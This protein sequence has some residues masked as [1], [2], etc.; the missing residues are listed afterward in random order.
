[1][2]MVNILKY[3]EPKKPGLKMDYSTLNGSAKGALLGVVTFVMVFSAFP[4]PAMAAT[5]SPQALFSMTL[6]APTSNP[7]RRQWAAIITSS[8]QSVG[9]GA[10]LVF[11]SFGV[12]LNTLFNCPSGC[13][14]PTYSKGG[15]DAAFIGFG[16]GTPLPDF[17]TQD[18]VVYRDTGPG[19]VPPVGSNYYFFDNATYNQLSNQYNTIFDPAAR[20]PILQQMV[21]IVAQER[22]TLV[23]FYPSSVWVWT[24]N[25]KFYSGSNA[26]SASTAPYIA[27]AHAS[28]SSG[29]SVTI[30]ETGDINAVNQ[31]PT[32]AQNS[33]YDAYLYGPVTAAGQEIDPR[34]TCYY[35]ALVTKIS[36]SSDH[37]TWT[38]SFRPHTF[39][40]GVPVTSNDYLFSIMSG[41]RSDVGYVGQGS[42]QSILGLNTQFTYLN[43]TTDYVMNGTYY[44]GTA[45][46]GF[47]PNTTFTAVNSTAWSFHM[48]TPYV[49]TNPVITGTGSLAMH[50]YEKVPAS[51]WSSSFLSGF[52]GSSGGLSTNAVTVTWDK[53]KY[54][55][56]G[57]Y[58]YVYGPVGDGPY[59]YRGYDPVAQ[60]GTLVRY[61]G[62]WNA[63]GLQALGEFNIKTI[64]VQYIAGKDA[65]IAA[66]T[67]G[68]ANFLDDN[69]Q[70]NAQDV[71]TLRGQGMT[72]VITNDPSNGWQEMGLN[73]NNP[74]FGTGTGTPLGQSN[75]SQAAF[76]ARM[77]RKAISY[78]IP[79]QYIVQN[80]LGGL[81]SVGITQFCPCFTYA[82]PPSVQPDPYDPTAAKSFLAAAGYSTGV[83][84][85]STGINIPP[86][87][88]VSIGGSGIALPNFL[89]GNTFTASG[90]FKV[91][92]ILGANSGG[93]A[94]TLEQSTDGG[95]T[96]APVALGATN[97]G[98]Y[99]SISYTPTT[100]GTIQYRVFFTGLPEKTVIQDSLNDPATVESLVPPIAK[101]RPLN[102][103]DIQY[104]TVTTL[105]VGTLGQ[106]FAA[107]AGS[108]NSA[109]TTLNGNVQ[110]GLT[111]LQTSEKSDI[112]TVSTQVNTLSGQL[113]T[114]NGQ[115]STLTS[116]AYAALAVAIILGLIAIGLSRRKP[117]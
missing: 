101:Q 97:T 83:A 44:H 108:I 64:H 38:V 57:S 98:G 109:L 66:L 92:P 86:A 25:L 13:P 114:L 104:S 4:L 117:S 115:V 74:Y 36:S 65:A 81:G 51:T 37:L 1:M 56:N 113:S 48:T 67:N 41:L 24:S 112:N 17:G 107:L 111:Q 93:F 55:G 72:V 69:Y 91:D 75:P 43:G 33:F 23:L 110:T 34:C 11:V 30:A 42:L 87:P 19:D 70:F 20:V 40:D 71:S 85:P 12:L 22:P 78:L 7:L 27:F 39:Q 32:S 95:K 61:D 26:I 88:T 15:W 5:S 3:L 29:T 73:L 106:V 76:A 28:S 47:T 62:Y 63:S 59:M 49:F 35:N 99:F 8:L 94:I 14:P 82:Y 6:M 10:N 84:P 52:T 80:L 2:T 77:V 18:V 54:G 79:R 50:I 96:W 58:A 45:P 105:Q 89:L 9:I 53:T 68:Q 46:S 116:V 100:N 103:T 21:K 16:G 60:V 102:V 31:L 90:T